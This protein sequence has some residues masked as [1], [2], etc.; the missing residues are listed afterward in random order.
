MPFE[1]LRNARCWKQKI[2]IFVAPSLPDPRV[3]Q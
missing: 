3:Y 2:S 1:A